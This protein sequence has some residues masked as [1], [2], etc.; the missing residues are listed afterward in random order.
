[1]E[2]SEYNNNSEYVCEDCVHFQSG[3]CFE[4]EENGVICEK[5]MLPKK[6]KKKDIEN[7]SN[8]GG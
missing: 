2:T 5:F 6:C 3:K 4:E 8:V 7:Q 1:M